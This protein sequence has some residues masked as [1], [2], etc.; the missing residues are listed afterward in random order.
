MTIPA[1]HCVVSVL[2]RCRHCS[3][4]V[5]DIICWHFLAFTAWE[6]S[7]PPRPLLVLPEVADRRVSGGGIIV[8]FL[9][10]VFQVHR[11]QVLHKLLHFPTKPCTQP[12]G[13]L[14][15]LRTCEL[16]LY[17]QLIKKNIVVKVVHFA[18]SAESGSVSETQAKLSHIPL[19]LLPLHFDRVCENWIT[20]IFQT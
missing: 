18:V 2:E 3:R 4:S 5:T 1:F 13:L 9:S 15:N 14:Q 8:D 11:F 20:W 16:D 19:P 12:K 6:P 17:F 7:T 10:R